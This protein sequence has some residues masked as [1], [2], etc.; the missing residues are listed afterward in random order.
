MHLFNNYYKRVL[1]TGGAGFIGGALIRKLLKETDSVIYNLVKMGYASSLKSINNEIKKIGDKGINR[2]IHMKVDISKSNEI[3]Q[4]IKTIDPDLIFH[5]A[6]ESHVDRSIKNPY[7]FI[8]SNIVGTFRLLESTLMHWEKLPNLRKN[9]FKLIHISTDE[10]FG[11]LSGNAKFNERTSYQPRS[12]YSASKAS[13]DHLAKAWYFTY[14][15]PVIVTNCSNNYGPWQYP[16]KLIPVIIKKA[17]KEENIPLYGDGSNIRDWIYVEDHIAAILKILEKGNVG[18]S[19][20]IGGNCEYTNIELTN[21]IC[22]IIDKRLSKPFLHKSLIQYVE[23]RL[24][25]DKRYAI[26]NT[27]IKT[28]LGWEPNTSFEIGLEKTVD[29]FLNNLNW[30]NQ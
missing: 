29:W 13:S 24:G 22:N 27:K 30:L 20:C 3:N 17:L 6:A 11:S 19:Y 28:E 21:F 4:A 2:H 26:D 12:P 25:H 18:E 1:I 7:H 9:R 23:D 14:G 16:E 5:L 15:L 8:N 10:V